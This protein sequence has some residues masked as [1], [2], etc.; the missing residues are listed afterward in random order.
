MMPFIDGLSKLLYL[1]ES[2]WRIYLYFYYEMFLEI[3]R[4][5]TKNTDGMLGFI[6]ILIIKID[7]S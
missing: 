5:I 4:L 7:Q 6:S 2:Y 3:W 1:F